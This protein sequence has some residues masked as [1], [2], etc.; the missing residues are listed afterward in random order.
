MFLI[1]GWVGKLKWG[2]GDV[3][4]KKDLWQLVVICRFYLGDLN[5]L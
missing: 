5:K 4:I 2:K 3:Q 1:S